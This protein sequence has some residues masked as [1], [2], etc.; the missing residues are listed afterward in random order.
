MIF[1]VWLGKFFC[2]FFWSIALQTSIG[3]IKSAI[4]GWF[5]VDALN[6]VLVDI[7]FWPFVL[8][9]NDAMFLVV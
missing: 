1:I 2:D 3:G 9:R 4:G 7:K 8:R 6:L 5:F